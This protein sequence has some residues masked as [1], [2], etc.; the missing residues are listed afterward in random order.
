MIERQAGNY[1]LPDETDILISKELN[2]KTLFI[3]L[4]LGLSI[5]LAWGLKQLSFRIIDYAEKVRGWEK[6]E[7]I[8]MKTQ[9]RILYFIQ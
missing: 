8:P 6:T 4:P 2:K 3:P 1:A 5:I 9:Q 7:V